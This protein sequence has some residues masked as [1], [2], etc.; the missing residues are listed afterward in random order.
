M[1]EIAQWFF[2]GLMFLMLLYHTS[3]NTQ[4]QPASTSAS[5]GP[6]TWTAVIKKGSMKWNRT[7]QAATEADVVK[8]LL[9]DG[10][11]PTQIA[12]ITRA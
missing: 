7:I 11:D 12:E 3:G 6:P 4:A 9:S 1:N 10:I 2:L 5:S 8:V